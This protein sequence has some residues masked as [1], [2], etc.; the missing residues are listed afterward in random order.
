M[1]LTR[2]PELRGGHSQSPV[3]ADTPGW[4]WDGEGD[5]PYFAFLG[6]AD[7]VLVTE[8]ST[9]LATDAAG[10]GRPVYVL[11]MPGRSAKMARFHADLAARGVTRPFEGEIETW[12][13]E[14]LRETERAARELLRRY[15]LT[16]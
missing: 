12:T 13:Y 2:S 3:L 16:R 14:P 15:D 4:I 1:R 10:T 11:P 9:N 7:V 8:D 6:A 5:N